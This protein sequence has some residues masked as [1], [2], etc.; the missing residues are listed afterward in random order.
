VDE[1][2][3]KNL[4][5]LSDRL[6]IDHPPVEKAQKHS[7]GAKSKIP[8][9]FQ[10]KAHLITRLLKLFDED[11]RVLPNAC[12]AGEL[13]PSLEDNGSSNSKSK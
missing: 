5:R 10:G 2:L 9:L 12:E 7:S 13:L 6:G 1:H 3:D 4:C 8:E 11:C